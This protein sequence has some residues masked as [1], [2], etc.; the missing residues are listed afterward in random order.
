MTGVELRLVG[1][2]C[3]AAEM[4]VP[5]GRSPLCQRVKSV[6]RGSD[7]CRRFVE[8]LILETQ[9]EHP[10][11]KK[12]DALMTSVCVPLRIGGETCG[13]LLAGGYREGAIDQPTRNRLRHLLERMRIP[14]EALALYEYENSTVAVDEPQHA[15]IQR[16]VKLAAGSLIHGLEHRQDEH[17]RPMPNYIIKI[18]S[19]IQRRYESPPSLK[20]AAEL[21]NLSES[22]FCRAFHEFTGLRFVEYIHAVRIEHVCDR[23]LDSDTGITEIAFSVGFNSLSQFNRVFRKLKGTAPRQWRRAQLAGQTPVA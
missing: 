17:D 18:C 20:E 15:A 12:C 16:W 21:C 2:S 1:P 11:C 23:L 4:S 10:S 7:H 9:G 14:D 13:Y 19:I 3:L 8:G 5:C 6:G 22:Y